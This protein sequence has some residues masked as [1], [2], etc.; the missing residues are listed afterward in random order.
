MTIYKATEKDCNSIVSIGKLSV[1][2]SHRGSNSD[3][4]M[5]E[6]LEKNY[7]AGVIRQE[8]NDVN[9]FYYVINHN[10]APVGFSKLVFDA[11]H[12]DIDAGNVAKLDRIYL[13]K[14]FY[15][16]KLGLELLNFNIELARRN[17]QSGVWLYTWVENKRAINFYLKV[18]FRII[19]DYKFYVNKTHYDLS[20]HMFLKLS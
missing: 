8:L 7:N 15:G 18:G 19:G 6:Y 11:K 17:N 20:H 1:A 13:L 12:P 2:E 9:N 4:V 16:L 3:E 14:E 5:N 10:D